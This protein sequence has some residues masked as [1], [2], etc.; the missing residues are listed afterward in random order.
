MSFLKCIYADGISINAFIIVKG[1]HFRQDLFN[2]V[3]RGVT[4]ITSNKD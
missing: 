1:I 4:I 2:Y 3:T